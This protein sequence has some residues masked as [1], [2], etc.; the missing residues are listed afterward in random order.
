MTWNNCRNLICH[1]N[2]QLH[3]TDPTAAIITYYVYKWGNFNNSFQTSKFMH[4]FR[5]LSKYS[6]PSP[7]NMLPEPNALIH[8]KWVHNR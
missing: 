2:Q 3:W 8:R 1:G 7:E 4:F 6:S 5:S